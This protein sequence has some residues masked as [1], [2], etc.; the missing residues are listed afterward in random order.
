MGSTKLTGMLAIIVA[1]LTAIVAAVA[2]YTS[3]Q[4]ASAEREARAALSDATAYRQ[5]LGAL[6]DA[7]LDA[8]TGQ[9]G[10]L[11][12]GDRNY[13]QPYQRA[14]ELLENNA[15][16]G[17]SHPA[18]QED[19]DGELR[20]LVELK[21]TE[22]QE[23]VRLFDAG[24][25]EAALRMVQTDRGREAMADI[26]RI[27]AKR[28]SDVGLMV[29]RAI[30]R[31]REYSR[32]ASV[33]SMLLAI[34]LG[35][36]AITGAF[37]LYLWL[38]T[39]QAE[40]QAE[41]AVDSAERIEIIAHELDHRM[42]N[43]FTVTQ[44]MLRQSARGRGDDVAVYAE[45]AVARIQ[46]MS[47][48]YSA[49][50]ELDDARSLPNSTIIEQVVRAQLLDTHRFDIEGEDR[51]IRENAVSPLALILHELT[52]NALKYGAW[53]AVD[54]DDGVSRVKIS[55][56]ISEDDRYEMLWDEQHERSGQS[57]PDAPG[58]GS[59]LIRACAAQ[60]G[61]TV[62]HDWHENGVRI[63]LIADRA[64]LGLMPITPG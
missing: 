31:T 59:K 35:L 20:Q 14:F 52:T 4:T 9:R 49:T 33:V 45:Q 29:D 51:Q 57:A 27:I 41:E 21:L 62:H 43:M 2:L 40:T 17:W 64:R 42:K 48:A 23:T 44:S 16:Q 38:R 15:G 58:Y 56:R 3:V 36:S 63:R 22:M 60:L 10:Y 24:S 1:S 19:P 46:A 26:R 32:R 5:S 53:K 39:R 55:W 30:E 13:L 28:Q 54:T 61:G 7:V 12:T 25:P 34:L 6:Q 37:A 18:L 47:H 11:L 50:R 8:E